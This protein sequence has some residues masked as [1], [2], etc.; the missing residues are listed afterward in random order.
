VVK[1]GKK[2]ASIFFP[3]VESQTLHMNLTCSL[4]VNFSAPY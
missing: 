4:S 3:L 2:K 1:S